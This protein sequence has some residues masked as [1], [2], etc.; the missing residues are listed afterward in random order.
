MVDEVSM[1]IRFPGGSYPSRHVTSRHLQEDIGGYAA[2]FT[3]FFGMAILGN[4][5]AHVR[6]G[7]KNFPEITPIESSF[8][9]MR[10][11]SIYF[12]ASLSH[13]RA[14]A[15]HFFC[16]DFFNQ[17]LSC[18]TPRCFLSVLLPFLPNRL[19]RQ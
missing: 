17:T 2:M 10:V 11:S 18:P 16:P 5:F 8:L 6:F 7:N 4:L 14:I 15:T 3:V 13:V 19:L 1:L 9:W 12:H